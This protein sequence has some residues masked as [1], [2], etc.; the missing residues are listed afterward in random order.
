MRAKKSLSGG[1]GISNIYRERLL[2]LLFGCV[3]KN[4]MFYV[5][6]KTQALTRSFSSNFPDEHPR[7]ISCSYLD[8][9][10]SKYDHSHCC[11]IFNKQELS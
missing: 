6:N 7:K 4:G 10:S 8:G 3:I 11:V 1:N 5:S 2:E 9:R